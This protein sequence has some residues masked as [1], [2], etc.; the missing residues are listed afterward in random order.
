[1]VYGILLWTILSI[2]E[3][4]LFG[5]MLIDYL[6]NLNLQFD[7]QTFKKNEYFTK[8]YKKIIFD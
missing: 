1:M 7:Q 2:L 8:N 6:K 4:S 3:N 5:I